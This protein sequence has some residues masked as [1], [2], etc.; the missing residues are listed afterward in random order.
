MRKV[1][2][3]SA[4]SILVISLFIILCNTFNGNNKE[5]VVYS[6]KTYYSY[7]ATDEVDLS[8]RLYST[9]DNS[10][11]LYSKEAVVMLHDKKLE[12]M[13]LVNVTDIY[14]IGTALYKNTTLYEYELIVNLKTDTLLI[15]ECYIKITFPN[16]EYDFNIG[17]LE[18]K[19]KEYDYEFINFTNLYGVSDDELLKGIVCTIKNDRKCDI[20]ITNI[21]IGDSFFMYLNN[22]NKTEVNES[23]YINDYIDSNAIDIS[24]SNPLYINSDSNETFII[25]IIYLEELYLYNF[26]MLIE[27]NG[28]SSYFN[29]FIYIDSN[30]L[31]SISNYVSKGLRHGI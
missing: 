26:Y 6:V 12:N 13:I 23:S 5:E 20:V 1:Y 28:E 19:P 31:N 2:V 18:I 9:N 30:D 21:S 24:L 25:P 16:N 8:I 7:L 10:L 11:L 4:V 15:E 14:N 22:S 17:K 3:I 29:N 27:M